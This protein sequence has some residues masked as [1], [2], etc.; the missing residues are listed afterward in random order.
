MIKFFATVEFLSGQQAAILTLTDAAG[1]WNGSGRVE[2]HDRDHIYERA[3]T[4]ASLAAQ[5]KGGSLERLTVTDPADAKWHHRCQTV[6]CPI[7]NRQ[8]YESAGDVS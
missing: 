5:S 7:C 4:Q 1:N 3:Y 2:G 6:P 8:E